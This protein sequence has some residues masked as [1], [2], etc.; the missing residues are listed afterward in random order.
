MK[1]VVGEY[2]RS[3]AQSQ[4]N[5]IYKALLHAMHSRNMAA[6]TR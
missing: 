4:C 2:L 6:A 3:Y 5:L 1:A